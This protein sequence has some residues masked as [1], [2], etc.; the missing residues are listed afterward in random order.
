MAET[1]TLF[2]EYTLIEQS[3]SRHSQFYYTVLTE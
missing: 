1:L 2:I 3:P